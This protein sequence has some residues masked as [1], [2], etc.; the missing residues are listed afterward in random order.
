M[1]K[2]NVGTVSHIH[3]PGKNEKW[4]SA[5]CSD[6]LLPG[7]ELLCS[8][9]KLDWPLSKI[10]PRFFWRSV[11]CLITISWIFLVRVWLLWRSARSLVTTVTELPRSAFTQFEYWRIKETQ[12]TVSDTSTDV[13][14]SS[15]T[16]CCVCLQRLP[17]PNPQPQ[18][19][20]HAP[21]DLWSSRPT[22]G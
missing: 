17:S 16:V 4:C 15:N 9:R 21:C 14:E 18:P 3:N 2:C 5:S 11:N 12:G 13:H 7:N 22:A 8:Q 6:R 19:L 10:E 1:W 20:S